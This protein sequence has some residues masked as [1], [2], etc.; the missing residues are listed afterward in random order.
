MSQE[1]DNRIVDV[2]LHYDDFVKGAKKVL[3]TINELEKAFTF[4]GA[5]KGVERLSSSI[6]SLTT[7][8]TT[9]LSKATQQVN[10]FT[11]SAVTSFAGVTDAISRTSSV[12]LGEIGETC[13][14]ATAKFQN[15]L[16][17]IS[18]MTAS[19]SESMGQA[20][21]G[22]TESVNNKMQ[23]VVGAMVA[24]IGAKIASIAKTV[25]IVGTVFAAIAVSVVLAAR[26]ISNTID[27]MANGVHMTITEKLNAIKSAVTGGLGELWSII[28][29]KT[30]S[31]S[32]KI[33]DIAALIVWNV[34]K[35]FVAIGDLV[36]PK[37][38]EIIG[39]VE[40]AFPMT[41]TI[42]KEGFQ[43]IFGAIKERLI[44]IHTAI[45]TAFNSAIETVIEKF[46][47]LKE[48]VNTF[49]EKIHFKKSK[50]EAQE[51]VD[52]LDE[53]EK[54][55]TSAGQAADN[56]RQKLDPVFDDVK[57]DAKEGAE[58]TL[59]FVEEEKEAAENA[60][61]LAAK[62]QKAFM[63]ASKGAAE[64]A[65]STTGVGDSADEASSKVDTLGAESKEAMDDTKDGAE[66]ASSG[67]QRFLNVL[68][69]FTYGLGHDI[70]GLPSALREI[71]KE[72]PL[73]GAAISFAFSEGGKKVAD[74]IHNLKEAKDAAD[75]NKNSMGAIG[76]AAEFVGGKFNAL[77]AIAFGALERIGQKALDTGTRLLKSLTVDNISQ[78]WEEY[79][80][81]LNSTQT[82]MASTGESLETVNG[83]LEELNK[84]ADRTIYSFSDM[85]A[86]IGKFTNAGVDLDTAV[87]AIKGISNEAA[88]SGAN[89]QEASRAMYNFAQAISAGNVKL[90][91]WKSI[92][93]ANMATKGFKEQLIQTAVELGTVKQKGDEYISVT[94]DANGHTSDAF[95]A[96]KNFNNSLSST[97]MT[98]EVLTKTLAKY[99]DENTKFGQD[100]Y[101]AAQD[102]KTG[103]QLM[104]TLKEAVGSGWSRTFELIIGDLNDAK[105]FWTGISNLISPIIDAISGFRNNLLQGWN[106]LGGREEII[107]ALSGGF[108]NLL[109]I[110]KK[111]REGFETVIPP[112]TAE[113]L[114]EIT[115]KISDFISRFKL[116]EEQLDK[117]KG[118]FRDIGEGV[119][120][121]KNA[122]KEIGDRISAVFGK[123]ISTDFLTKIIDFAERLAKR[124]KELSESRF[125]AAIHGNIQKIGSVIEEVRSLASTV[126]TEVKSIIS[127][128][129]GVL[130][131]AGETFSSKFK[132]ILTLLQ[133]AIA[134]VK[135]AVSVVSSFIKSKLG[136][137]QGWFPKL[138]SVAM[139]FLG[140]IG[141]LLKGLSKF[142]D[143]HSDSIGKLIAAFVTM[144]AI[145]KLVKDS[146]LNWVSAGI[147]VISTIGKIK[148]G[149]DFLT[150][151]LSDVIKLFK[152]FGGKS[153]LKGLSDSFLSCHAGALKFAGA[154]GIVA[155]AIAAV[156]IVHK[157]WQEHNRKLAEQLY[158]LSDAQKEHNA[159]IIDSAEAYKE[160][161]KAQED[162]INRIDGEYD[163]YDKLSA[164]LKTLVDENGKVK[165][166]YESRVN[167]ILHELSEGLGYEI[168]LTDGVIQKYD[169]VCSKIDEVIRKKR[170]AAKLSA[171]DEEVADAKANKKQEETDYLDKKHKADVDQEEYQKALKALEIAQ[172]VY[173]RF[174]ANTMYGGQ[175][176]ADVIDALSKA[177]E[178]ATAA[179]NALYDPET[180]SQ[181]AADAAADLYFKHQAALSNY[182]KAQ[183]AYLSGNLEAA[184]K[185]MTYLDEGFETAEISTEERLRSQEENYRHLMN[186]AIKV[187][188]SKE[189]IDEYKQL[190][191]DAHNE[192]IKFQLNK[193]AEEKENARKQGQEPAKAYAD[194]ASE[195]IPTA[196]DKVK[197]TIVEAEDDIVQTYAEAAEADAAYLEK[198]HELIN[199]RA[200][201]YYKENGNKP[202]LAYADSADEIQGT[203]K[204]KADA[205]SQAAE[206]AANEFGIRIGKSKTEVESAIIEFG[207][208]GEERAEEAAPK[209]T[210]AFVKALSKDKEAAAMQK[211]QSTLDKLGRHGEAKAEQAAPKVTDAFVS[212]L[213]K[214]KDTA[215]EAAANNAG[216]VNTELEGHI[217]TA[218][219]EGWDYGSWWGQ[220]LG[221]GMGSKQ[222]YVY[223]CAY[224]L[225]AT[226]KE[227]TKIG[228]NTGSPSK[229][230]IE[231]GE[232]WDEGLIVGMKKLGNKVNDESASISENLVNSGQTPLSAIADIMNGD[233]S[234]SMTMTP[235]IDI[236]GAANSAAAVQGMLSNVANMK[237]DGFDIRGIMPDTAVEKS[238]Q[239]NLLS[240]LRGL[241]GDMAKF[242]EKLSRL[243][244]RMDTGTLVG[245]L[246]DPMDY[247]LG[248]LTAAKGR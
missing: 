32:D 135:S 172:Q 29:D 87:A 218:Y 234:Q 124:F 120:S 157:A 219:K 162:A 204:N 168:S 159:A 66:E 91:D 55:L 74:Y 182:E 196:K 76:E 40:K 208:A 224:A 236:S 136:N 63:D 194:S 50:Q 189:S 49:A 102:I 42:L 242:N 3:Q 133:G 209:V 169:E 14:A 132:N 114:K 235:V 215:A 161:K 152:K 179:Y 10:T 187:G 56:L 28:T 174:E 213:A 54:K 20:T 199:S 11:G 67:M 186:E 231:F 181:V 103:K 83:Y 81:K 233:F 23:T 19:V 158:G 178:N 156:V 92:E 193:T 229:F 119:S 71:K 188:A 82:I 2:S 33:R 68:N 146:W 112:I 155:A 130:S 203:I 44:A 59:Q 134:F 148:G 94:K 69:K 77:R 142:I 5:V 127:S 1:I 62:A 201:A 108:T 104:D 176:P 65:E 85:T 228:L 37:I 246:A 57:N 97:W 26:K 115:G 16:N 214:G 12:I 118:I 173:D 46:R 241:R 61:D 109:D 88:L 211:V 198:A 248:A 48:A 45:T 47:S 53:L 22:A 185:Y 177:K 121:V 239:E 51:T 129:T 205:M 93:N 232:F 90:I 75:Q 80:L 18:A 202:A 39:A 128:A 164:E 197:N 170:I 4:S 64:A 13:D 240:E 31:I 216:A 210:D 163:Y 131:S 222:A 84:Y 167:F 145:V 230:A 27:K 60:D 225:A 137:M 227:A 149:L 237:L 175:I 70:G 106:A 190:W 113:R 96:T 72:S 8:C 143:K 41:T 7:T 207:R 165:D 101:A 116:S 24:G 192:L 30:S 184:E 223:G 166:G 52:G 141:N 105:K 78:G 238:K 89:A 138:L 36:G 140:A 180:G 17:N 243:Q 25:A 34:G 221:L 98:T 206:D 200:E 9:G 183:E 244:V 117:V 139:S 15:A 195:Q 147:K 217:S 247:E 191:S 111:A 43:T 107:S 212:A 154:I 245:E 122:F 79:G 126:W 160:Q 21:S 35:A 226:I 58:S 38:Q 6:S 150:E 144:K 99:S 100:A 153:G 171:V 123:D 86:N 73:A 220:G 151:K 95:T 110:V 125:A